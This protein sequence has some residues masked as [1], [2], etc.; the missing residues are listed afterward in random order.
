[1]TTIFVFGSNLAGRHGAGAART[2]RLQHG[3]IYGMGVGRTGDSYAIPTLD[4]Q[5]RKLQLYQ[6]GNYVSDFCDYAK[7]NEH[8]TFYV[9][10]LGCG[11]AG[12][13]DAEI[14]PLFKGVSKNCILPVEWLEYLSD[15]DRVTVQHHHWEQ[16]QLEAA[17]GRA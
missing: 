2:A 11:L 4:G 9:T 14:A 10:R 7:A 16:D 8:L 5:L 3:A 6:I 17:H 13:T 12:F 1:M 15:E